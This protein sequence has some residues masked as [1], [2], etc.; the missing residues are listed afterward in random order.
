MEKEQNIFPRGDKDET[1]EPW[2][3]KPLFPQKPKEK[4]K[5]DFFCSFWR[6]SINLKMYRL[7]V[8]TVLFM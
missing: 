6:R 3:N 1:C 7:Y 2:N 8:I 5:N 4:K